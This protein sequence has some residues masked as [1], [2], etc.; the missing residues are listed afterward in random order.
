[1]IRVLFVCHGNICRS[2]VAEFVCKDMV[3]RQGLQNKISIASAATST[4]E[5]GSSI[6]PPARSI[7]DQNNIPYDDHRAVQVRRSDYD[8]YDYFLIMDERNRR[9]IFRIFGDDPEDK[10]HTLLSYSKNPRDISDPWYTRDF[11]QAFDDISEGCA[12]FLEHLRAGGE[13]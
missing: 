8:K 11:Q 12:A 13:I 6:Y 7:M 3:R 2:P 1:M 10:V 5:L 4:E 9:N